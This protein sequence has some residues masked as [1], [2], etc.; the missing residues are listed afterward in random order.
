MWLV[1]DNQ[2]GVGDEAVSAAN[3][4]SKMN[5]DNQTAIMLVPAQITA[6]E[7]DGVPMTRGVESDD[8]SCC[9]CAWRC[10]LNLGRHRLLASAEFSYREHKG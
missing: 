5:A 9:I 1:H 10:S 3:R 2:I 8:E 6:P 4:A 7:I